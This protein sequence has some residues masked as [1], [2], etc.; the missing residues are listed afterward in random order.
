MKPIKHKI[1]TYEYE[2][3]T[4][5]VVFYTRGGS[6]SPKSVHLEGPKRIT[7][8]QIRLLNLNVLDLNMYFKL[9]YADKMS[10]CVA[11]PSL[12]FKTIVEEVIK[13]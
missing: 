7:P 13:L 11:S 5:D 2:G 3:K 8:K 6:R 4:Y 1:G 12:I 9:A 10:R